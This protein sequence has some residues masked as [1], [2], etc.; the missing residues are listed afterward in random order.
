MI[1]LLLVCG[2]TVWRNYVRDV[3][4]PCGFARPWW[5][6]LLRIC[7]FSLISLAR[8]SLFSY[9]LTS[10]CVLFNTF[11]SKIQATSAHLLYATFFLSS[12]LLTDLTSYLLSL[13][14]SSHHF[15]ILNHQKLTF[16]FYIY[17]LNIYIFS[18]SRSRA[19]RRLVFCN[20]RRQHVKICLL[21]AA[22]LVACSCMSQALAPSTYIHCLVVQDHEA[23]KECLPM[24]KGPRAIL[25]SEKH[26]HQKQSSA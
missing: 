10:C 11:I 25:A 26:T 14:L 17:K 9:L 3:A 20:L 13:L 19:T 16:T 5:E 8:S 6:V 2:Q 7:V 22:F 24:A 23:L 1:G 21:G 4:V 15:Y 12:H 18:F